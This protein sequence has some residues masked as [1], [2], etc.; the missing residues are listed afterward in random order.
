[1]ISKKDIVRKISKRTLLTQKESEQVLSELVSIIEEELIGG[2]DVS[3]VGFGKFF[4]YQH[5]SRPVR[6]PKTNEQMMLSPFKSIKF[7]VSQKLKQ[8]IKDSTRGN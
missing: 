7:K 8:R 1:M 3:I 6:N 2:N 4:L 5:S